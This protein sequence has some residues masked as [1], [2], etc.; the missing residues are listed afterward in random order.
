MRFPYRI[1]GLRVISNQEIP[2]V[3]TVRDTATADVQIWLNDRPACMRAVESEC[4]DLWYSSPDLNER[5]KPVLAVWRSRGGDHYRLVY[6][7]ETEFILDGQGSQ[8]WST[9][10]DSATVADTATYLS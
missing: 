6:G 2:G 7:D 5:G 3:T 8:I 10:P 1:Y 9:W 4:V